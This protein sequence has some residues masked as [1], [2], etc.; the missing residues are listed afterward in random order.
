MRF[1][2]GLAFGFVLARP[3]THPQSG[4]LYVAQGG[5]M[6]YC[7]TFAALAAA[8]I[9]AVSAPLQAKPVKNDFQI[10]G[11]DPGVRLFVRQKMEEGNRASRGPIG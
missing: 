10:D 11:A 1:L 8:F 3:L 7:R 6:P 4:G 2:K 5:A 9:A